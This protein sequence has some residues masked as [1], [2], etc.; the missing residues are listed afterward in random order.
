M[1]HQANVL[2]PSEYQVSSVIGN[3]VTPRQIWGELR[4]AKR[5]HD[6]YLRLVGCDFDFLLKDEFAVVG[7][8]VES[9]QVQD[10][11]CD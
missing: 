6:C 3:C 10:N 5:K 8:V 2:L 1:G 11:L 9:E 7:K 4:V